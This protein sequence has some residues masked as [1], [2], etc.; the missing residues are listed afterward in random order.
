MDN[1]NPSLTETETTASDGF[2]LLPSQVYAALLPVAFA[3]GL[4]AGYLI[5]G[6]GGPSN[7]NPAAAA[8]AEIVRYEVDEDDD[9]VYGPETAPITIV[10]FSDYECPFC[11]RWHAEVWPALLEAYPGQIR[12]VYRDFPLT[13]I[14]A[15]ATPAASAANC[16]GEQDMFWAFNELL[17]SMKYDLNKR[18]YQT[19]AQE[20]NLNMADFN[21]CLESGRYNAEVMADLE[22]ASTL[23]VRSTPTFFVNGIP[24]VGAQPFEV[25][26]Q[27]IDD[28]L[29]GVLP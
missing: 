3:I 11:R 24:V 6:R 23:G 12:L 7:E 29:A 20:L 9:P 21:E 14:H 28:E 15:N 2:N 19:Y 1:T 13:N 16:A 22:Y 4:F 17:Y 18:S 10:E 5:W 8:P 25:F 27:L 26:S